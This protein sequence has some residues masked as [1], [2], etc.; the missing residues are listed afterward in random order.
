MSRLRMFSPIGPNLSGMR[1][2]GPV[3]WALARIP[4]A[5]L[6][7][8][9][10]GGGTDAHAAQPP[11]PFQ[12]PPALTA[13]ARTP[14]RQGGT[15]TGLVH[16]STRGT[17]LRQAIV[18]LV[19]DDA[20]AHFGRTVVSD[21]LGRYAFVDVPNGRYTLGFHHPLL[22]SLGIEP[23]A[24]TVVVNEQ[25][26]RADLAI[27]GAAQLHA[28]ICDGGAPSATAATL[29]MGF[30]RDARTRQPIESASVA[31]EWMEYRIAQNRVDRSM[32]RRNS[33]TSPTGWFAVCHIPAEGFVMLS[34]SRGA[35]S[36]GRVEVPVTRD[37]LQRRE[38][39]LGTARTVVIPDSTP[40][41]DS[42]PRPPRVMYVGDMRV[43]GTVWRRGTNKPLADAQVGIVNGPHTRTNERGEF[44]LTNAPAGT[45]LLEVR[46]VGY[47]PERHVV[48]VID[49]IAPV[50]AELATLKSVLDTVKVL[51]NFDRYNV[52]REFR[53]RARSGIGRYITESDI[54]RRSPRLLSDMFRT[55]P[56]VYM[57]RGD[58][59]G[60]HIT[61]RGVFS[62]RCTP[63]LVMNGFPL[64]MGGDDAPALS[65]NEID[66]LFSL[67]D[68]YG[69]EI[70][71]V[72]QVPPQFQMGMGGCGAIVVW[73]K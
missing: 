42:L 12:T 65:A 43:S 35:D 25:T 47:Y 73:T 60:Q 16:D 71:Q 9:G 33:T 40:A 7:L 54:L 21:S 69:V 51:A 52:R 30:V 11:S 48:D 63:T 1:P 17:P 19:A 36:T 18:Q 41:S 20:N 6:A 67:S 72:G 14:V 50:R 55:L 61:M 56:G 31:V 70:Y 26:V 34:A 5:V 22:D 4:I 32:P 38:L 2:T 39:Y 62:F 23:L 45:R 57:D 58:A 66:A 29:L 68:V 64:L 53:D 28:A 59:F 13:R 46:A 15:V 37:M 27:P 10:W 44:V 24:R 49:S 8:V 3:Q